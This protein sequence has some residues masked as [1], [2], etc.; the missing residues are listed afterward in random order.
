MLQAAMLLR[1]H[2]ENQS[3]RTVALK[4]EKGTHHAGAVAGRGGC[5]QGRLQ[6][7][8]EQEVPN[9][10]GPKLALKAVLGLAFWTCH[11]ASIGDEDVQLLAL[12]QEVGS[13]LP[14]R[15]QVV[16]LQ[17]QDVDLSLA[18]RVACCNLLCNF[19]AL[20]DIPGYDRSLLRL[21]MA[22]RA[23]DSRNE[24]CEACGAR[25]WR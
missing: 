15:L 10:V 18:A 22:S 20:L 7:L 3:V 5:Q 25:T 1:I 24:D 8:D 12:D 6:Q 13:T 19:L 21:E 17:L 11:D 16:Q 4:G 23:L 2:N 9:M 14:D